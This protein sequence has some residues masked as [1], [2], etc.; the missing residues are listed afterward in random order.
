MS[1]ETPESEPQAAAADVPVAMEE[2]EKEN[3]PKKERRPDKDPKG[4]LRNQGRPDDSTES[5]ADTLTF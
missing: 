2:E 3:R 4:A 1:L 5:P